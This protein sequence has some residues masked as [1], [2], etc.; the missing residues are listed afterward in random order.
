MPLPPPVIKTVLPVMFMM[1]LLAWTR[2]R[3]SGYCS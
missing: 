1:D 3:S 2:I